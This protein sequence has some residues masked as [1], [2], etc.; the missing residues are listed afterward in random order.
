VTTS[1]GAVPSLVEPPENSAGASSLRQAQTLGQRHT[2][3]VAVLIIGL[4]HFEKINQSFGYQIGDF[5]LDEME[6]RVR[7]ILAIDQGFRRV[8]GAEFV[9]ILP[10]GSLKDA[11][12]LAREILRVIHQS[13]VVG[14]FHLELIARIGLAVAS[15]HEP[16]INTLL[17]RARVALSAA[18]NTRNDLA[19]YSPEQDG[20]EVERVLLTGDLRHAIDEDQLF[21]VYQPKID[22][23]TGQVLA[24]EALVRWRHPKLGILAPDQFIPLAEESGLIMHLTHDVLHKVVQ[25]CQAWNRA[26]MKIQIAT[27]LS[28]WDL[29]AGTL[30]AHVPSLLA[31][32]GVSPAQL[33]LEITETAIMTNS[34]Q[35]LDSLKWM[36]KMGLWISIDDFGTGYSSLAY[37]KN[38]PVNEIK[39]DRSFVKNMSADNDDAVIVQTAIDLAHKFG[40][41]VVAEGVENRRTQEMLGRFKCDTAQGFHISKPLSAVDFTNWLIQYENVTER[42]SA[43]SLTDRFKQPWIKTLF[44]F[45][46]IFQFMAFNGG[47]NGR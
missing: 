39:I 1:T 12:S 23:S 22:L 15:E 14:E 31:N 26:G 3:P 46:P 29:Q 38:L 8:G 44:T 7:K 13:F 11:A 28:M 21:L 43:R 36:S 32:Y 25:Q 47:H 34:S 6:S 9:V 18:R 5:L 33:G 19:V 4:D 16:T 35:V 17:Q 30:S 20:G 40:L 37:L 42:R 24:V 45:D 10:F 41:K 2:N 27:N